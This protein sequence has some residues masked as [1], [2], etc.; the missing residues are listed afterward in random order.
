[1]SVK[2][3]QRTSGTVTMQCRNK[4]LQSCRAA[5]HLGRRALEA[6]V[7]LTGQEALGIAHLC[8]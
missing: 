7:T 3:R 5:L 4:V 8:S 6:K 2:G 1:M